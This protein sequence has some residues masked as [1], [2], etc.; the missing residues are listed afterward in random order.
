MKVLILPLVGC[1]LLM[2]LGTG[3]L[4]IGSSSPPTSTQSLVVFLLRHAE[5]TA[6]TADPELTDVGQR[7]ADRLAAMLRDVPIDQIHSSD[8]RRTRQT[9]APLLEQQGLTL[10]LYDPV[11]LETLAALLRE[12]GGRH[13]VVG[14]SNTTPK[15]VQL[16]GG[17]A[18]EPID[19]AGEYDRLYVLT[20]APDGTTH[21]LMLRY[22]P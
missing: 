18:G 17:Q 11:Q 14:H 12:S 20:A 1:S 10:E 9:V 13:V 7:R 5:K 19:D 22:Q 2:S 6:E 4:N 16:L 15:L 21:T 8:Y 3:W